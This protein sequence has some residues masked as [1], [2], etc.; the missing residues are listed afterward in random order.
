M[1]ADRSLRYSVTAVSLIP[2]KCQ[3]AV[4]VVAGLDFGALEAE[5]GDL[6]LNAAVDAGARGDAAVTRAGHL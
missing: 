5:E 1:N 6:H 3:G 4:L 2:G